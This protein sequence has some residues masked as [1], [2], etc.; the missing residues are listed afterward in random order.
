[1]KKITY[2]SI[3]RLFELKGITIISR[4]V[5]P[6]HKRIIYDSLYVG[7]SGVQGSNSYLEEEVLDCLK[8]QSRPRI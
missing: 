7:I 1:M 6:Q 2:N 8:E 5:K 3:L 4:K